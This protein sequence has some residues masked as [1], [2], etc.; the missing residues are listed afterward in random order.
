MVRLDGWCEGGHGQQKDDGGGGA[1]IHEI[2][3]VVE[4][5]GAYVDDF[6]LRRHSCQVLVFFRPSLPRSCGFLP[7]KWWDAVT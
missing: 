7:G 6:V 4:S 3:E 5:P 1:T 2:E